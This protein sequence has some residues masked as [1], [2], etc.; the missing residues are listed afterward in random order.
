M[1][2]GCHFFKIFNQY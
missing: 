1:K 2:T